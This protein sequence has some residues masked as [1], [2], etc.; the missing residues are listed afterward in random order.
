MMPHITTAPPRAVQALLNELNINHAA[1]VLH[2]L[3]SDLFAGRRIGTRGHDLAQAWLQQQMGK[4]GLDVKLFPFTQAAAVLNLRSL[5]EFHIK[6]TGWALEYRHEFQEHPLSKFQDTP[7]EGVAFQGTPRQGWMIS[8]SLPDAQTL[9]E[10]L[11]AGVIGMLVPQHSGSDGYLPK[12]IMPRSPLS[13]PV[14]SVREDMLATLEGQMIQAT[15][16]LEASDIHGGHVLG[17][18][19]GS[20]TALSNEPLI[21]GAHFDGVGDDVAGCRL[22]GAAD[23]AAGV[24]VVLEVARAI[25]HVRSTPRRPIIFAAFDG[26]EINAIGSLA[27]AE[28]LKREGKTPTVINLDGAARFHDSIWAE[29]SPNT[30]T[31]FSALDVAGEWLELPLISGAVGS[32]NRRYAQAGFPTVGLALGGLGGHTPADTVQQ[33]DLN[34]MTLAGR[35]LLATI[36]QLGF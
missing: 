3:C 16:P 33:V 9:S 32:D 20:D 13:V 23:N 34:S 35:L 36:W 11:A 30:D 22:P 18:L 4:Q 26:E 25:T 19:A 2:A 5:P 28:A 1:S 6:S 7:I 31:L 29:L 15:M 10:W 14:I 8:S 17:Y 12:R 24:A 21:V 27:Y